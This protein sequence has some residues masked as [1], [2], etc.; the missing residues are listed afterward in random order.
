MGDGGRQDP[1]TP[2]VIS[3]ADLDDIETPTRSASR[4]SFAR[5]GSAAVG[6][7][8]V[9]QSVLERI[10]THVGAD[11]DH[12]QGG[13]LVGEVRDGTTFVTDSVIAAGAVAEVASFTFTHE[14]WDHISAIMEADHPDGQMVGWYHS[15]PRFGIFLSDYDQF[16]HQNFFR[17][18]WQV[19]YV[20][21]P[22]HDTDGFF[23]WRKD[24]LVRFESWE[25]RHVERADNPDVPVG[26]PP[27]RPAAAP[28]PPAPSDQMQSPPDSS[29]R[30]PWL[31]AGAL[32]LTLI[33]GVLWLLNDDNQDMALPP[34]T[35]TPPV[36]APVPNDPVGIETSSSLCAA[37]VYWPTLRA[38][39]AEIGS[40]MGILVAGGQDHLVPTGNETETGGT[41]WVEL[42]LGNGTRGWL[43]AELVESAAP[44]ESSS[45][46]D[47]AYVVDADPGL[48]LRAGPSTGDEVVTTIDT[49][50][51]VTPSGPALRSEGTVWVHV[52]AG[53]DTGWVAAS[54]LTLDENA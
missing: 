40:E 49:G 12:E 39:P 35:T 52:V 53:A 45:T 6:A 19:A 21:D 11:T 22:V 9:D 16:I 23:G 3:A 8:Q 25:T 1:D 20:V 41:R 15:H 32:V 18:D 7:L 4:K 14:T 17:E 43:Q 47:C 27:P 13:V 51:T 38:E 50:S 10:R 31:I 36:P 33:A 34:T 29:A 42:D 2:L 26:T 46:T 28:P 37:S 54:F 5:V 44:A 24:E 30:L 48:N